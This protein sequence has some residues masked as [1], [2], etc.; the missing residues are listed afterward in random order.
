[1]LKIYN[2]QSRKK[3]EFKPVCPG[4]VGM[5][6]CGPTVYNRIHIG[7]ARTFISFDIIRRYLIWSGFDVTFVQNV[8][9]VDDKI[10]AKS[11]DE[12][13]T[14]AEI[15]KKYTDLFVSDMRDANVLD[16]D[17]RPK[18]TQEITAMID[19]VKSLIDNGHAYEKDG[20]VYF[21]VSSFK[22]YGS[23]SGRDVENAQSGHRELRADGQGLEERKKN[24]ADFALWKVAKPGEPS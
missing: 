14:A 20:D 21:D 6:V 17:I 15:A 4:K 22:G 10:I 2:S 5:Y 19:L 12:N 24:Q 16:P 8:T 1:M 13:T 9:D 23:L 7:N 11:L 3:E 18:A